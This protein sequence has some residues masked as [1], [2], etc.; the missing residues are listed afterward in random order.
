M[1]SFCIIVAVIFTITLLVLTHTEHTKDNGLE[2]L[3]KDIKS[4]KIEIVVDYPITFTEPIT[5][6]KGVTIIFNSPILIREQ[7]E[8]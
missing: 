4:G 1:K 5:I 8:E 6:P 2:R 7:E 3:M